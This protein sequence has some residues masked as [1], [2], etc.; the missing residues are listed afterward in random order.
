MGLQRILRPSP[1]SAVSIS[2]R[3]MPGG[4]LRCVAGRF[5]NA[6]PHALFHSRHI[7]WCGSVCL[8]RGQAWRQHVHIGELSTRS[9]AGIFRGG[10]GVSGQPGGFGVRRPGASQSKA[11]EE[12]E[13]TYAVKARY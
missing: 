13:R 9:V 11:Q 7:F 12:G 5:D 3:T 8:C 2:V 6:V 10:V 4:M 1:V